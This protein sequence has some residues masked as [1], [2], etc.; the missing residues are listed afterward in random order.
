M[1]FLAGSFIWLE[2]M[3]FRPVMLELLSLGESTDNLKFL[4]WK[5]LPFIVHDYPFGVG[6]GLFVA[7][8]ETPVEL[9]SS[10]RVFYLE[11]FLLH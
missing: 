6:H 5:T 4:S 1:V 8:A 10:G 3:A 2:R 11:N 9:I 7:V